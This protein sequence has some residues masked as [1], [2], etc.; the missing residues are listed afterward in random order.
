MCPLRLPADPRGDRDVTWPLYPIK[1]DKTSVNIG[2]WSTVPI[3]PG[4]ADGDVNRSIEAKVTEL[5]GHKSLYSDAYYDRATF[6]ALYGGA[7]YELV[8]KE[9]DPDGRLPSLYDKAVRAR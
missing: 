3:R 8:K 1:T 6:D 4:R 5:G 7:A 2:F 9:Y